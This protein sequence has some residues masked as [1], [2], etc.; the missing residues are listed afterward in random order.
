MYRTGDLAAWTA[1]GALDYRGRTDFQVKIRGFRIELGEIDAVLTSHA[2][3]AIAVT[4]GREKP[5][6]AMVLVSYVVGDRPLDPDRLMEWAA[7]TLPA[8]MVPTAIVVL[9]RLP[10]SRTGKLDRAALP[11]PEFA[12]RAHRAPST[13]LETTVC[14]VFADVLGLERIGLDDN[15]FEL[16]G[17]LLVATR[18]VARLSAAVAETVPVVRVFTTPTP[19]GIVG[20]LRSPN[21]AGANSEAAFDILLPVRARTGN[22]T[23][24]PLF[25]IHP[26]GGI[27]W[28]FAG[29]AAH[30]DPGRPLYGLQSPALSS[31]EPLPDSI[32][33]WARLYVEHI[34]AV[35]PEGPYHLLGWSLGGVLAHAVAVQLQDAGEQVALLAMMD[36]R[37]RQANSAAVTAAEVTVPD[38]LGGLLGEQAAELGLDGALE[39]TELAERLSELPEPFAS[40]GSERIRRVVDAALASATLDAAYSARSFDGDLHFFTA[41]RDD[42][43]CSVNA[44]TWVAA[45]TG[46]VHNHPVASTH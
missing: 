13:A 28:S 15:F 8:H 24:A 3:V 42:W 16:G 46:T 14:E 37:L 19:A 26:I 2:D 5:S 21:T 35:Q 20:A 12:P 38:L 25:C 17:N 29:L 33:D 4:I 43:T 1:D 10:L 40:F 32:E 18:L 23:A 11:A 7:R 44:K 41:A 9:D 27:A 30:L 36:S 22:S 6:G 45:V 31:P 39:V 34:R